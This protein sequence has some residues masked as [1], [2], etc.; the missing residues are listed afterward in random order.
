M[1]TRIPFSAW[2]QEPDDVIATVIDIFDKRAAEDRA[3]Q[4]KQ[5]KGA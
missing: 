4:R 1:A 5:R 3:Q 2:L